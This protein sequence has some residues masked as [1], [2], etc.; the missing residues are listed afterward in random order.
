MSAMGRVWPERAGA[1]EVRIAA[2]GAVLAGRLFRPAGRPAAVAVLHGATGVPMGYYRA[3]AEWLA[4]DRGVAVLTYDYRDFGQSARGPVRQARATM[5]D[6]GLRDQ[7]AA[8]ASARR[9]M[10]GVP[11]WVIGHSLGG[12]MLAFHAGMAD[13]ARTVVVASGPVHL[14]DH[15]AGFA[16]RARLLWYGVAPLATA[17]GYLPGRRLGLGVDLPLGVYRDWR[18]WCTTR[19]FHLAEVGHRLPLPDAGAVQGEMRV[20]AVADD[21]WVPP[22]AVWRGMAMYPQAVK[23]QVVLRP[24]DFGLDR[25]GHLGAFARRN[26]AVWPLLAD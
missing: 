7:P 8:L 25:I 2:E 22:S 15:P 12:V 13:V 18:R 11:V 20:V 21:A 1:G 24:G 17:L 23:R 9:L 16:L 5:A 4:A 3:F 10:P 26:A 6:W 19:G 14:S